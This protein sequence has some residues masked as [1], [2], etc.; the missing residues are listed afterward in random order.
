MKYAVCPLLLALLGLAGCSEKVVAS[1]EGGAGG[2]SGYAGGATAAAGTT[3]SAGAGQAGIVLPKQSC[4]GSECA[5]TSDCC[6][7]ADVCGVITALQIFKDSCIALQ[8]YPGSRAASCPKSPDFCER[9]RCQSFDGCL[10]PEAECG[11]WVD[12]FSIIGGEETIEVPVNLGCVPTAEFV[13][14][15]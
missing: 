6:T 9:G 1:P 12:G 5:T 15:P 10:I 11:Y 13:P 3:A 7:S 8:T 2:D 4:G 14:D